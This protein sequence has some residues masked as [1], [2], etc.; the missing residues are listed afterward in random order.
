MTRPETQW[1]A[2]LALVLASC[3][4]SQ[5]A[6]SIDGSAKDETVSV[7][8]ADVALRW[9]LDA[10]INAGHLPQ[11]LRKFPHILEANPVEDFQPKVRSLHHVVTAP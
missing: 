4:G 5:D 1:L 7:Q 3:T 11:L 8:T 9:L 10:G 2:I 6:A